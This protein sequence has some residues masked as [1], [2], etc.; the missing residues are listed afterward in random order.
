[1]SIQDTQADLHP[2]TFIKT[3]TKDVFYPH[4]DALVTIMKL[5]SKILS[6]ILI[7]TKSSIDILF[8]EEFD[9]LG[10]MATKMQ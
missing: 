7:N 3:D 2:V 8:N 5:A 1:M 9:R 4:D 6:W 10:L